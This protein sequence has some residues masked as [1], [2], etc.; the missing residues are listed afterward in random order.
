MKRLWDVVISAVLLAL[1]APLLLLLAGVN[2]VLT[3][4]TFFRQVRLGRGLRPFVIWKFQTMV[5]GPSDA[6]TVTTRGDRRL[7]PF[8]R[9]LRATKL[10]E[11]PQLVNVLRGEMSL[12]GPR[13]LTPNEIDRVPAD[14]AR[15]VYAAR[16]GMTGLAA[17]AFADEERILGTASDPEAFYFQAV[18]PQKMALEL[19]YVRRRGWWLDLLILAATPLTIILPGPTRRYLL[20]RAGAPRSIPSPPREGAPSA[21]RGIGDETLP[22]TRP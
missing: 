22:M 18:L 10:D 11:L 21:E 19:A 15:A 17:V 7:T 3:R 16:P 12:V 14:V 2:W 20:R 13:A 1:L 4:R 9:L 8:G 5:D 6:S